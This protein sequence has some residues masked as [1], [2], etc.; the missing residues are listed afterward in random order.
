MPPFALRLAVIV[1]VPVAVLASLAVVAPPAAAGSGPSYWAEPHGDYESR[2][3]A[4]LQHAAA[5]GSG[6]L[7]SQIAR[8]ELGRG[9]LDEAG[10]AP[11]AGQPARAPRRRQLPRQRP[12]A[13]PRLPEQPAACRPRSA[14]RSGGAARVQVLGRRA[15]RARP[16]VDVGREPPDQLPRR[17]VPGGTGLPRRRLHQQR[18]TGPL[19]P[20]TGQ[21]TPAAL[22]RHQGAGPAF[23]SGTATTATSAPS[24]RC[25]T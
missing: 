22:D 13:H 5:S 8:L 2:R 20:A 16:A 19:A 25:S 11:G 21:G 10:R 9:P 24:R 7:Y 4:F 23:S 15:R 18:Q 12:A 3:Q 6:G 17:P 1:T 14:R